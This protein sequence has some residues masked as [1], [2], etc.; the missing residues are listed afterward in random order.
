MTWEA[1][2]IGAAFLVGMIAGMGVMIGLLLWGH[3]AA[4]KVFTTTPKGK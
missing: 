2:A 1:Y 3:N 4:A